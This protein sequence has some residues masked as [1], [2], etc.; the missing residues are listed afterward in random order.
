MDATT[1]SYT[2]VVV[3]CDGDTARN[4]STTITLSDTVDGVD[5]GVLVVGQVLD[6]SGISTEED[7]THP[8]G[9]GTDAETIGN[10]DT[11]VLHSGKVTADDRTGLIED[12]NHVHLNIAGLGRASPVV[13]FIEDSGAGEGSMGR[14]VDGLSA[15]VLDSDGETSSVD[16]DSLNLIVLSGGGSEVTSGRDTV[17]GFRTF[18]RVGGGVVVEV[19]LENSV[20]L[21]IAGG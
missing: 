8:D 9:L 4:A 21:S 10:V 15:D 1:T 5:D 12:E 17:D 16:P 6:I 3:S 13:V 18:R 2:Q 20:G 7:E 11:K 19:G 14:E